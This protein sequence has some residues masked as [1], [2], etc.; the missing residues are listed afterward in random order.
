MNPD[1]EHRLLHQLSKAWREVNDDYLGGALRPAAFEL[2]DTS[3][4]LG[5]WRAQSRTIALSRAICTQEPWPF[6]VDV[7]KHEIAHQYVDEVLQP[8]GETAHGPA[9]QRTCSQL[10]IPARASLT[11]SDVPV[12]PNPITQRIQRLLKLGQ[13]PNAHEAQG[14]VRK[15]KQLLQRHKI[16][17]L[18][19][20]EQPDYVI[21]YLGTPRTRVPAAEKVLAG[22]LA[23]DFFVTAIWVPGSAP[24][25]TTTTKILEISGLKHHVELAK[26]VHSFLLRSIESL[27]REA[28]KFHGYQGKSAK[29]SFSLGLLQG[30]AAR[31]PVEPG[32]NELVKRH[33][34]LLRGFVRSRHPRLR[35][36]R[37]T[38][39]VCD[40][41]YQ[42]G[43]S[44]GTGISLHPPLE[45]GS[46]KGG[47]RSHK[48]FP[49]PGFTEN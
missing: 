28:K 47:K 23:R 7:L 38:T 42:H 6:V 27:W 41:A 21:R 24:S 25:A 1:D 48:Q 35:R 45:P 18:D 32:S 3:T 31:A 37:S 19:L 11:Q 5:Q 20:P 44:R 29:R 15:A 12:S 46:A 8:T 34:L 9:F 17:H 2:R 36:G 33:D 40:E 39:V 16:D 43:H 14:A 4:T 22:I 10:G 13:S 49:I 30:F 26:H